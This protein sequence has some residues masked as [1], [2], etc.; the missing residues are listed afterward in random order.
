MAYHSTIRPNG[1]FRGAPSVAITPSIAGL[2]PLGACDERV[3]DPKTGRPLSATEQ[4]LWLTSKFY[5]VN[6][7]MTARI[8][9]TFTLEQLKGVIAELPKRHPFLKV[10][11]H[12]EEKGARFRSD[13]VPPL[14]IREIPASGEEDWWKIASQE[15][16]QMFPCQT[17][18][19]LRF[20]LLRTREWS[21]LIMICHQVIADGLSA[22][23][24]IRDILTRLGDPVIPIASLPMNPPVGSLI[25]EEIRQNLK[26]RLSV[27]AMESSLPTLLSLRRMFRRRESQPR[28]TDA[29]QS[30]RSEKSSFRL[31]A[32][33][34]TE[35]QSATLAA[36]CRHQQ[37]D[38]HSV[39]CAAL[40]KALAECDK[41]RAGGHRV[42]THVNLRNRLSEPVGESLGHYMT[43]IETSADCGPRQNVW[44]VARQ[45]HRKF[46]DGATDDKLFLHL[47]RDE[48]ISKNQSNEGLAELLRTA[49]PETQRDLSVANLG[50][51]SIP[52]Q[53]GHIQL[54]S[55]YGPAVGG[56]EVERS[57]GI[58]TLGGK[59]FFTFSFQTTSLDA[60][61]AEWIK[62]QAMGYLGQAVEW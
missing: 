1:E 3:E 50:K 32:W 10:R 40:L 13:L 19:L 29:C 21:D 62:K 4:R 7:A 58:T 60:G 49:R 59:T 11:I 14:S 52:T 23:Y 9:G 35:L 36:R 39:I 22:A 28:I 45:L 2:W 51:L 16:S 56:H 27:R 41:R 17:G 26:V 31:L 44:D 46:D 47:L 20:A 5:P 15:L 42:S 48:V 38:V 55:L 57:V 12:D 43:S 34:L 53:Y 24:L 6:F 18:P 33:S 8:R 61:T 30:V 54:E 25:P 37:A